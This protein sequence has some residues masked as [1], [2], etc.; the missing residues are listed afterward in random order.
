MS[1]QKIVT[2]DDVNFC[3]INLVVMDYI[4]KKFKGVT[5]ITNKNFITERPTL[6]VEFT[7]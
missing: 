4:R 3:I 1:T 2:L 6:K 5:K 7:S